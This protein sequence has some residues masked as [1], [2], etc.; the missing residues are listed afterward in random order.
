M[1]LSDKISPNRLPLPI[2]QSQIT[3]KTPPTRSHY[4]KL[5]PCQS[6]VSQVAK[7]PCE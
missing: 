5:N 7:A 3:E 1:D 6:H 4:N 2:S